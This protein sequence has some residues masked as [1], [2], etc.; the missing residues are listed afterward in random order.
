MEGPGPGFSLNGDNYHEN[1]LSQNNVGVSSPGAKGNCASN[2]IYSNGSRVNK[3]SSKV[4]TK[5]REP[6][7]DFVLATGSPEQ[8]SPLASQPLETGSGPFARWS[9]LMRRGGQGNLTVSSPVDIWR[10]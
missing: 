5:A 10:E 7:G 8:N 3:N 9:R 1:E 4:R 2:R 6:A